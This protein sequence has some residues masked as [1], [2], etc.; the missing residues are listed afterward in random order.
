MAARSW[1]RAM[2]AAVGA[3]LVIG[4]GQLGI[5]Y[6][7]G[8]I[9][10]D[11]DFT[12]AAA[13]HAQLT[14]LAFLAQ[15]T[16]VA[17]AAYGHWLAEWRDTRP[18]PLARL[19]L[20][21]A[22]AAGA[23]VMLPLVVHRAHGVQL[24]E[25]GDPALTA[26]ITILAGLIVGVVAAAAALAASPV[27]GNLTASIVWLWLAALLSAV[28]TIGSGQAWAAARLGLLPVSGG[29]LPVL[30]LG[31]PALIALGVAAVARLGGTNL[32]AVAVSGLAGPALVAAAY[33]IGAPGDGVQKSAYL[34][35]LTAVAVGVVVSILAAVLR[36]PI[37]T[38]PDDVPAPSTSDSWGG[39]TGFWPPRAAPGRSATSHRAIP[40]ARAEPDDDRTARLPVATLARSGDPDPTTV[41]LSGR[42]AAPKRQPKAQ[43]KAQSK[44]QPKAQAA[45]TQ[46][47]KTQVTK[48]QA[49][50]AQAAR[51][52]PAK[53][54]VAKNQAAKNQAAKNQAAESQPAKRRAKAQPAKTQA[55][56]QAKAQPAKTQPKRQPRAQPKPE[57]VPEPWPPPLP[58]PRPEPRFEPAPPEPERKLSRRRRRELRA[59]EEH[60]DWVRELGRS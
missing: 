14:W 10:W 38:A 9:R 36:M 7:L 41:G 28:W 24:S 30:L 44:R 52:E 53:T 6:G 57:P 51:S 19:G 5:G 40:P 42:K 23:T 13:W 18:G 12:S 50:K 49:T 20:A 39:G 27:A 29:W 59:E 4:A 55:K 32:G 54:Q 60:V 37:R 31:A 15:V 46:P 58:E 34:W 25:P 35:A 3:G 26:A 21:I 17:G 11:T 56:A 43:P 47:A 22:A 48:A 33:L 8:I 2:G 1:S 16:V 45:K